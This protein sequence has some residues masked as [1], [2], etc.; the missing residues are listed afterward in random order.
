MLFCPSYKRARGNAVLTSPCPQ[1]QLLNF[2]KRIDSKIRGE[3]SFRLPHEIAV[4]YDPSRSTAA[5]DLNIKA[6]LHKQTSSV[7]ITIF[8]A[9]NSFRRLSCFKFELDIQLEGPIEGIGQLQSAFLF[10]VVKCS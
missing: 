7:D 2:N 1:N 4:A 6:Q 5:V 9:I 10:S 8:S 3:G